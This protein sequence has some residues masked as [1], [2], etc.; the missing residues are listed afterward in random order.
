MRKYLFTVMAV[1]STLL[2]SAQKEQI[3]EAPVNPAFEEY[4][5]KKN[6]KTL[7]PEVTPE[8]F[9]LGLIP[10]TVEPDFSAYYSQTT[11]LK[12]IQTFPAVYDMRT[13]GRIT[14]VKN[15]GQ[16]GSC[17]LFPTMGAV[18]S[19]WKVLGLGD[20]D[21]SEDNLKNCHG[22]D[23]LPCEGGNRDMATS[24][25]TRNTGPFL[26]SQDPYTATSSGC[27]TGLPP[28]AYVSDARFL[29]K[30]K[31]AIKQ[32]LLD[33]GA[34]YNTFRWESA[35]YNSSNYTYY[36]SGTSTELNHAVLI[37]GWDDNKVT[38]GGTGAWIIKGSWGASWGQNGFFYISY[39][40]TKATSSAT[41][42]PIR[43]DYDPTA[44]ISYYDHLG[45]TTSM[46]FGSST[47]YGLVKYVPSGN[48]QITK[49]GTWVPASNAT[50]TVEIYNT[51]SGTTL[52]ALLGSIPQKACILPGYYTFDLPTPIAVAAGND[53]YIKI[54]YTTPGNN[55]P[56][57]VE[58][59]VTGLTSN[60][61]IETGKCWISAGGSS[62][63]AVGSNTTKKYDVCIKAY[64]KTSACTTIA[65]ATALPLTA[66]ACFGGSTIFS[67]T[68]SGAGYTYQWKVNSSGTTWTNLTNTG[69]YS[70]VNTNTLTI[71]AITSSFNNKKYRCLVTNACSSVTSSIVTL[72]TNNTPVVTSQPG[73]K[74]I[75]LG[76]NTSFTFS[77]NGTGKTYKWQISTNGGSTWTNLSNSS[78][79]S[80]VASIT[81]NISGATLA[82]SGKKYRCVI[83]NLC[84]TVNTNAATL[85]VSSSKS[86]LLADS[87][88]YLPIMDE[89]VLLGISDADSKEASF[90]LSTNYPNPFSQY[91]SIEYILSE[92]AA[93]TLEIYNVVGKQVAVL[94]NS[95]KAAGNYQIEF[96]GTE[97][98][99]GFYTYTLRASSKTKTFSQ[100]RMMVIVRE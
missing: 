99:A 37:V 94:V 38:A 44:K 27:P 65:S 58:S 70:N 1:L 53:Y 19:R 40:D 6:A 25:F 72:T 23:Y 24:Y 50:V 31:N 54:K 22:F 89:N 64:S 59:K 57:P 85:T 81:L 41:Y 88:T 46:G 84:G 78:K 15:Q 77:A 47:G 68:P 10:S 18:E 21:L 62:W 66:S 61:V 14:S 56:I 17:W 28:A 87:S 67:V 29:P 95:K 34:V 76:G 93:V 43:M 98:P 74:S 73:N 13:N 2:S 71:S 35:S 96:D 45:M 32:A 30:D 33:Y 52:S 49:V 92:D 20:F 69:N 51:F 11:N 26:E 90:K 7:S 100:S 91:T 55:F 8:G 79:Y 3:Q 63:T 60:V 80:N 36:Y 9:V 5:A 4:M 16:C 75:S 82:L 48:E 12:S 39:N 42:Y 97:L 86:L 83:T